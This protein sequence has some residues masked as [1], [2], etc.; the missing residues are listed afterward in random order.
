MLNLIKNMG[1]I[2]R[3]THETSI[4]GSDNCKWWKMCTDRAIWKTC[5]HYLVNLSVVYP[6]DQQV[7]SEIYAYSLEKLLYICTRI[8]YLNSLF[9]NF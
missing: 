9:L 4:R 6:T 1:N 7:H 2:D 8:F 3:E 5:W